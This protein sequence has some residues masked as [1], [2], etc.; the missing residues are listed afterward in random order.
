MLRPLLLP[1]V[2]PVRGARLLEQVF[3]EGLDLDTVKVR[4]RFGVRVRVGR[5]GLG[6][7]EGEG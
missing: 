4:V 3:H 2:S 6:K 7:V 1:V 5:I